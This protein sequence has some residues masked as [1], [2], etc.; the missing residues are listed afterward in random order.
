MTNKNAFGI[1]FNLSKNKIYFDSS[2]IGKMPLSSIELMKQYYSDVGSAPMRAMHQ[3][4]TKSNRLLEECREQLGR[5][6]EVEKSQISF[7]PT[8]EIALTNL[9]LGFEKIG[10][11]NI[12]TS[13][14]ED[15]SILAPIIKTHSIFNT[16]ID[17]LSIKEE[18]EIEQNLQEKLGSGE[19]LVILS[20]LTNTN[21]VKRNWKT[22]TDICE[23]YNSIFILDIS[24]SVG[25]EELIFKNSQPDILISS[26]SVGAL[27]PPGT[28]FQMISDDINQ[29]IDPLI[30]GGNSVIAL[31]EYFY[32][33]T[34]SGS[35][36]ETG[37]I[38]VAGI[39]ALANSLKLLHEVGFSKIEEHEKKLNEILRKNL[40]NIS[41]IELLDENMPKT[42]PIIT[43][44]C[45]KF[46]AHDLAMILED[47]NNII[48]RSGALCAHLFMYEQK[49]K[50]IVRISTHLYNCEEDVKL[51]I[52]S[53]ET[54]FS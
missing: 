17:Y 28:S 11:K 51:L 38:N 43:F 19:N 1:E 15:H 47:M 54:V 14:L 9:L 13:V 53:L 27:G 36:F 24:N 20:S 4:A 3:E 31:E 5:I 41:E 8:K 21:G 25:H 48:V 46:E 45:D 39:I 29:K 22:I 42:G 52:E 37:I 33:L 6:F 40:R 44:G 26:G 35:K 34:S 16:K 49:F 7:L 30:V 10:N 32:Q 2:S 23:D 50:D 12:I 18:I